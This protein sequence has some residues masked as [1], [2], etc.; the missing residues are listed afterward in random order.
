MERQIVIKNLPE[1]LQV[2]KE[3]NLASQE[4]WTG[5]YRD[6]ARNT[7]ATVLKQQMDRQVAGHLSWAYQK[8]IP[9]RKNGSYVR[10]V[11]TELGNVIL[12]IPR[13]RHFSPR[14]IIAAYARR[15]REIDH[16]ILACFLLGLSTRK[17]GVSLLSLLGE[18][19][20]PQTV[21]RVATTLDGA[22]R[23]FHLRRITGKFRALILDGIIIKRKTGAGTLTRPVLVALGIRPD[24]K[25]E[26]IDFY[27][28]KAES[29]AAWNRFLTDLTNR[30]LAAPEVICADGG[31]GLISILPE[32]FPHIP[33]QR[34]WAHKMRNILDKVPKKKQ[35]AVKRGLQ[36][37]YSAKNLR[38]AQRAAARWTKSWIEKYP[39]AVKCLRDDL[40]DLLTCFQF[41]DPEFR[42]AIRTTNAIERRFREVR[43]RTRP[44]G[45]FSNRT[46]VERILY[47]VLMYENINQGVYPVFVLTQNT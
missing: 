32:V 22:V 37:I 11:L 10:H 7:I 42:K 12:A 3:M 6:A 23:A 14:G 9:D 35:K 18:K 43:R 45:V 41:D 38:E 2:V 25:K 8:G 16:L 17:V 40:E 34:C 19:V 26:V 5:E 30:G 33:L 4:E 13:T 31:E 27:L 47:A 24:G 28:A 20:S 15:V 21:S 44:M 46:S 29:G 1:A 39:K 36:K